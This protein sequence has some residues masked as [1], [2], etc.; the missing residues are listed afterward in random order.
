MINSPRDRVEKEDKK[1]NKILIISFIFVLT[2]AL[3]FIIYSNINK[4]VK[5]TPTDT[6]LYQG[7][8]QE[9]YNETLFRTTGRYEKIEVNNNEH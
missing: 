6:G 7:P 5:P 3:C 1:M 8:V 2:F 9:G 4:E